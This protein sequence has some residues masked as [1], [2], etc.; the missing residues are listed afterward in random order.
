MPKKLIVVI[1]C[2]II[3]LLSARRENTSLEEAE[4]RLISKMLENEKVVEVFSMDDRGV[5]T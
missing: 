3:A 5:E 1:I 2:F 4:S